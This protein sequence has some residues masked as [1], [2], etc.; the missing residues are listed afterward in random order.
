M[1]TVLWV[2]TVAG[3]VATAGALAGRN[4]VNAATNRAHLERAL[5]TAMG[6]VARVE[7]AIDATLAAARTY[8]EAADTWRVLERA[9]LP[10]SN[11]AAAECTIGLEAAGTRLDVNEASEEMLRNTFVALGYGNDAESLVAALA[12]WR[13]SDSVARPLGAE[14]DWYLAARRDAPRNAPLADI[15]ELARVRGF[16]NPTVFDS[17]LTT[18]PGRVSLAT[19]PVTVLLAVP[20]F[21]RE[22]AEEIVALQRAGTP[23][24][25]VTSILGL[26]SRASAD[27]IRA[28][29][30]DIARVTTPDPDA[31]I[32]NVRATIGA[33]PVSVTLARRLLRDA[34]RAVVAG[35][36]SAP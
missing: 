28:R 14:R 20:G 13:D 23:I 1:I 6:C 36:R 9:A 33:P 27:S 2:M 35:S 7:S 31:W 30:P 4:A 29:Y 11:V 10:L 18:E 25:D 26:V 21:T 3:I 15:R 32:L 16:E 12:D 24:A 22:T 17:V 5:W 8:D 19:A 34:K